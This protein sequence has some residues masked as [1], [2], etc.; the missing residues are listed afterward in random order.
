MNRQVKDY[1]A[2]DTFLL[3]GIL[4]PSHIRLIKTE[5]HSLNGLGN[6]PTFSLLLVLHHLNPASQKNDG[7]FPKIPFAFREL[8]FRV[9]WLTSL[10]VYK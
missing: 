6:V 7:P 10:S 3:N 4:Q 1:Y 2:F 9:R 8:T 5:D